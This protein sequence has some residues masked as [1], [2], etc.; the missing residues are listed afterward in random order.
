[1]CYRLAE[2]GRIHLMEHNGVSLFFVHVH[3]CVE[4]VAGFNAICVLGTRASYAYA[5][6]SVSNLV[7]SKKI[8]LDTATR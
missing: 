2:T 3:A 1:M 8:K 7:T 5:Q 4:R 6:S